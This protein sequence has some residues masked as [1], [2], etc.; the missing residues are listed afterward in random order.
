MLPGFVS[1]KYLYYHYT[2]HKGHG[3]YNFKR[4]FIN[5][6]Q[7]LSVVVKCHILE[8]APFEFLALTFSTSQYSL[9]NIPDTDKQPKSPWTMTQIYQILT[10]RIIHRLNTLTMQ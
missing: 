6:S 1:S 2:C 3:I 4:R 10:N 5:K 9:F 7:Y 8:L